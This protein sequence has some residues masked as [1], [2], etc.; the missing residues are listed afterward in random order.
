MVQGGRGRE[1]RRARTAVI[2][3]IH[4]EGEPTP[5]AY[6]LVAMGKQYAE[7][8]EWSMGSKNG[9]TPP[10]PIRIRILP[11]GHKLLGEIMARNA[12]GSIWRG[13]VKQEAVKSVIQERK[14]R[15]RAESP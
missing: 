13:S 2:E 4:P 11:E 9:K 5:T 15:G 14:S 10:K 7:V 8:A 6:D 3:H 1:L 12:I